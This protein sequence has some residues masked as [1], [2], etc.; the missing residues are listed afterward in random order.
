MARIS[1][2]CLRVVL[3]C[4][5]IGR[6]AGE[7][8]SEWTVK[9]DFFDD[10]QATGKTSFPGDSPVAAATTSVNATYRLAHLA[11]FMPFSIEGRVRASTVDQAAAILLAI[12]HWN[13]KET[14]PIL[15]DDEFLRKCNVRL[16]TEFIDTL[17]DPVVSTS[18]VLE[19][20]KSREPPLAGIIGAYRSAVTSP[21]ALVSGAYDLPQISAM[22]T[23]TDLENR[24]QYPYFS[25]VCPST[26]GEAQAAV[27]YWKFLS[28]RFS[29]GNN[30]EK[31]T[32]E[33]LGVLFV[34]DAYGASLQRAF[35]NSATNAGIQTVSIPFGF[36]NKEEIAESVR[37]LQATQMRHFYV[38]C[39]ESDYT[40]IMKEAT[41]LGMT[42]IDHFWLFHG[43]N[44]ATLHELTKYD[45]S[46][47]VK[48]VGLF[49]VVRILTTI[50]LLCPA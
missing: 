43:V 27:D 49:T 6:N 30:N 15:H 45:K 40:S 17:M 29:N 20:V 23:S 32:I 36:S 46:K 21:V 24:E 1:I 28:H 35:Q 19:R 7:W 33:Y 47:C 12:Y 3:L 26:E 18:V 37:K 50:F 25:R 22:S 4:L 34:R 8:T 11:S 44:M 48:S 39:F 14:S 13:H 38:I 42:G 41:E 9:P 16:T 10:L 31:P 2:P 5:L